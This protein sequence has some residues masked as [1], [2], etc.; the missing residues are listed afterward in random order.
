M[1]DDDDDDDADRT[2]DTNNTHIL[3]HTQHAQISSVVF[4]F[5]A[6]CGVIPSLLV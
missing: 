5:G 2:T 4:G 6:S 1:D 3:I